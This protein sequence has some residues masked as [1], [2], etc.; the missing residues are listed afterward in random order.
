M[1]ITGIKKAV[2]EYKRANK[3]G[4]YS[5]RYGRLM[6][7]RS[8]G[9]VWC[10]EFYSLGHEDFKVY[11]SESIVNLGREMSCNGYGEITM[12]TVREYAE[13]ICDAYNG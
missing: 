1:K 9:E 7:D 3:G 5:A 6:L 4:Y 11:A 8:T 12:K 13:K 10:D 2:G